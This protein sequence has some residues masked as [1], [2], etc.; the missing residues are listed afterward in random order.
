[1]NKIQNNKLSMYHSVRVACQNNTQVWEHIPAFQT[2][3]EAFQKQLEELASLLN[4]HGRDLKG[5]VKGKQLTWNNMIEHTLKVSSALHAYATQNNMSQLKKQ[6]DLSHSD[7]RQVSSNTSVAQ[8]QDIAD[9][10]KELG[11]VLQE[12][13]VGN[14]EIASLQTA[15]DAF[16]EYITAP[17]AAIVERSVIGS[18]I[19]DHFRSIDGLLEDVMDKLIEQF[20][21]SHLDF[22]KLYKSSRMILDTGVR[23][24]EDIAS[25]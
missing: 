24:K 18:R 6:F 13:G 22:Y 4:I 1:M 23:R 19:A 10:A 3:Y 9:T 16:R 5:I 12:Y 21:T 8:A 14:Q 11:S 20:H 2:A 7:L 25:Q 15:I 17:R